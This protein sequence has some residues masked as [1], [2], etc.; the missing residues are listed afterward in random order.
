M[1][2]V[3]SFPQLSF[4]LFVVPFSPLSSVKLL[5]LY[6][7]VMLAISESC[8]AP[9]G[10]RCLLVYINLCVCANLCSAH[11]SCYWTLRLVPWVHLSMATAVCLRCSLL[12]TCISWSWA[13][14]C[15]YS[16]LLRE[17]PFASLCCQLPNFYKRHLLP[18]FTLGFSLSAL[19]LS[20]YL[21]IYNQSST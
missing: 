18:A 9:S 15:L 21:P 19:T 14:S 13:I 6:V 11:L 20:I 4:S 1:R 17:C 5:T 12:R 3:S 10:L 2:S 7:I 16:V 8:L